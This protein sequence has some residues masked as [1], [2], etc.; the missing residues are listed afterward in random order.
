MNMKTKKMMILI[1]IK[2]KVLKVD[3]RGNKKR[4]KEKEGKEKKEREKKKRKKGLKMI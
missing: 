2:K 1:N 3:G 4:K